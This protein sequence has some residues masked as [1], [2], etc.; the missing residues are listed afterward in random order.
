MKLKYEKPI[1]VEISLLDDTA[2]G[3]SPPDPPSGGA[4]PPD[5]G[6]GGSSEQSEQTR[7]PFEWL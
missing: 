7:E 5:E 4:E 1:L 2:I 3:F 6:S